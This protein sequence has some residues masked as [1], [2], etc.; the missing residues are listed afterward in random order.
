MYYVPLRSEV[1]QW[2]SAK[3]LQAAAF[4]EAS[5]SPGAVTLLAT[6]QTNTPNLCPLAT[7]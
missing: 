4:T 1:T 6:Q 3:S 5:T 2:P 7:R